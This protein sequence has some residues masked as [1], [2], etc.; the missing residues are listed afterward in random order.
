MAFNSD[1]CV[2]QGFDG[3]IGIGLGFSGK[4]YFFGI[5]S[6]VCQTQCNLIKACPA[7]VSGGR[8]SPLSTFPTVKLCVLQ[9]NAPSY[10]WTTS[11]VATGS[12]C[13]CNLKYPSPATTF[14]DADICFDF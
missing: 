9:R 1:T 10:N 8:A 14:E 11:Y 7:Q 5:S 2:G 3:T 12:L 13:I 6:T 4:A